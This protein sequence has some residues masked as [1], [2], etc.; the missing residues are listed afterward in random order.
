MKNNTKH[1]P[2]LAISRLLLL[3]MC[4]CFLLPACARPNAP[5]QDPQPS[6][7]VPP[8]TKPSIRR[9]GNIRSVCLSDRYQGRAVNPPS[10]L[11]KQNP[12]C[13]VSVSRSPTTN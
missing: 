8:E 4:V 5:E 11:L 7:N 12:S 9:V 10:S 1:P 3:L 13:F 2:L 6:E